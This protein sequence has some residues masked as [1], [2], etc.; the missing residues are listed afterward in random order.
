MMALLTVCI[1]GLLAVALR[2]A[3]SLLHARNELKSLQEKEI[4]NRTFVEFTTDGVICQDR[5]GS[6]VSANVTASKLLGVSLDELQA[7][8]GWSV[9]QGMTDSNG[10]VF[11]LADIPCVIAIREGKHVED[12]IVGLRNKSTDELLWLQF[13]SIPVIRADSP[14]ADQVLVVF[15]DATDIRNSEDRY[16]VIIDSSP[17]GML[18]INETGQIT[19]TNLACQSM[20]GYEQQ[21]LKEKLISDLVPSVQFAD[22]LKKML[23]HDSDRKD[24]MFGE[25]GELTGKKKTG[26]NIVM[27]VGLRKLS[28]LE[29]SFILVTMVDVG[30][31]QQSR[32]DIAVAHQRYKALFEQLSDGIILVNEDFVIV[33]HNE[34]AIRLLKYESGQLRQK[35]ISSIGSVDDMK[36]ILS[37]KAHVEENGRYDFESVYQTREGDQLEVDI[38]VKY[39]ELLSGERLFQVLFRDIRDKKHAYRLIEKMAFHDHLTGLANR[40]LLADRL[41]QAMAHARRSSTA[42]GVAFLDLD[43]F[44]SINDLHGHP[45]GDA[46]LLTVASRMKEV[47]REEDTLA[48]LGGDEFVAVLTNLQEAKST[49][50][51]MERLL[52]AVSEPVKVGEINLQVTTSIGLSIYPQEEEV[53]ADQLLRQADQAMYQAKLSGKNCYQFFNSDRERTNRGFMALVERI[54]SALELKQF[55]LYYQP[56]VNMRTRKLMGLEALIR[57]QHPENGLL[58]PMHFLPHIENHPL[59]INIGDWVIGEALDQLKRWHNEGFKDLTVSVN[60]S[61]YQFQQTDF[62]EKLQAK[63]E[64]TNTPPHCLELEL[65]ESSALDDL[66]EASEMMARCA[67]MNVGIALDDF[68]TGYSSLTYLMQ[69]PASTIKIDQ[70]FVR[71]MLS[72]ER[73][74]SIL[75]GVLW[76]IKRLNR[77]VIA[78]GVETLEIGKALMEMGCEMAQGYGIGRPMP[79]QELD[80]WLVKWTNDADWENVALSRERN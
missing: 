66:S 48:R 78:E 43:G 20:F 37:R 64:Q 59:S 23:G 76:I 56:K 13:E 68:G 21:E 16:S 63:L 7:S 32:Q 38:S 57:W 46:L 54:Q 52:K 53:D 75:Q 39:L 45:T 71:G 9:W 29:G 65:L 62:L 33:D 72:D 34:E 25:M 69:L 27:E 28:T 70:S 1:V 61:A 12:R 19:L 47:M 6:V 36:V 50:S 77:I 67:A 42:L 55:V 2:Q 80:N 26:D 58:A 51:L 14:E 79:A 40:A 35:H 24:V 60:I 44:K 22:Q 8:T 41:K 3:N 31:R 18:M 74:Q 73:S 10:Q 4:I 15:M 11:D 17:N 5:N 30:E 49:A